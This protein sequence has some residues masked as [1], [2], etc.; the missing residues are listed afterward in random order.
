MVVSMAS[1]EAIW[2]HKFLIDLFDEELE[3]AVIYCYNQ[4]C[5][6]LLENLVFYDR[7]KNIEIK[8]HFIQDRIQ[9]GAVKI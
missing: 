6:K 8:Y 7:S 4:T 3:P 2:I 5:I 9:K 1:Y